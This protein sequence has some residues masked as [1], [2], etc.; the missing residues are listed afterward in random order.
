MRLE[1]VVTLSAVTACAPVPN[2][3]QHSVG[4]YR[5]HPTA[6]K[7]MLARCTNEPGTL[8][9]TPGC[10]NAREAA[11]LQSIGTLRGLAPMGLPVKPASASGS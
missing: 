4:Y 5:A 11:R 7:V 6:L 2:R 9:R 10:V 3:A 8:D 1:I